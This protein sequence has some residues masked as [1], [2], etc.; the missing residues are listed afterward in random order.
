MMM[1]QDSP[2]R[3]AS[4][5]KKD[6][7]SHSSGKLNGSFIESVRKNK[8]ESSPVKEKP[9]FFGNT[10]NSSS[11]SNRNN[12][13]NHNGNLNSSNN[14][15]IENRKNLQHNERNGVDEKKTSS[16]NLS[17]RN[18]TD[19]MMSE[20]DVTADD[21]YEAELIDDGDDGGGLSFNSEDISYDTALKL[22]K[23]LFGDATK[24]FN[25]EWTQQA[26]KF[27][28]HPLLKYGLVQEKGGPCGLLASVQA[29]VL[30]HLIFFP[31]DKKYERGE[32]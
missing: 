24:S 6:Y 21:I 30:K 31:V 17:K 15:L 1:Q 14:D 29:I 16:S 18:P 28:Q 25:K 4:S 27:C 9:D 22:K 3:M 13:S 20:V 12:N 2:P 19:L 8:M 32:L 11:H 23:L 7:F 26:F 5:S 10:N